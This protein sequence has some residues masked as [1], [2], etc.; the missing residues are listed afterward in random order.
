VNI[1]IDIVITVIQMKNYNELANEKGSLL[2]KDKNNEI[3]DPIERSECYENYR[4]D[5]RRV[6]WI[7]IS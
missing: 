7:D 4:G 6:G 1:N 3:I 5:I 2:L